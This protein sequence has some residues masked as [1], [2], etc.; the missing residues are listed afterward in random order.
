MAAGLPL[1]IAM[2]GLIYGPGDTSGLHTALVDLLRRRLPITPKRTA[3]CWAHV[4]DTA[5]GHIQMMEKGAAGEAY[6]LTGPRHT[7]QEAFDLAATLARVRRP[8]LH[9]G[10]S[11]L[12]GLATLAEFLQRFSTPRPALSAEGLRTLAGTTYFGDNSKAVRE[13]GFLA[14]PL[15][16]GLEQTI[17]HELRVLG[18]S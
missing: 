14:R 3:F 4:E 5:R 7:F 13:L 12:R 1:R 10:P 17:E 11:M 8:L 15:K 6:I 2:P 16:E 18:R 9:P